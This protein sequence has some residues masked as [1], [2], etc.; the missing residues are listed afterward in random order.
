MKNIEL[1]VEFS[2]PPLRVKAM[3]VPDML[4][5][6]PNARVKVEAVK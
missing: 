1:N 3:Y 5:E 2:L 6:A 4:G